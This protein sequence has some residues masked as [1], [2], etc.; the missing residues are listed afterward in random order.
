MNPDVTKPLSVDISGV[1][2][3]SSANSGSLGLS[4]QN[5]ITATID[6]SISHI[7]L[8]LTV[9][10]SFE[11]DFGLQWDPKSELYLINQ[12]M[13]TSFLSKNITIAI[14]IG[15]PTSAVLQPV[16]IQFPFDSLILNASSSLISPP[17]RYFALKRAKNSSQYTLGR[18]FLQQAYITANY[19]KQTFDLSRAVYT[20]DSRIFSISAMPTTTASG[21]VAPKL[22]KRVSSGVIAAIV[23]VVLFVMLLVYIFTAWSLGLWPFHKSTAKVAVLAHGSGDGT[24]AELDGVG[25]VIVEVDSV[26]SKVYEVAETSTNG[27][28]EGPD[29]CPIELG[30]CH[31]R[32]IEGPDRP[33]VEMLGVIPR[34]ELS[35]HAEHG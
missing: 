23:I 25:K 27:E 20:G 34:Y 11:K 24:K 5:S 33:P 19:D 16:T 30:E 3:F 12:T 10:Q 9:C 31:A 21:D 29:R 35:A 18:A 17:S 4:T 32:E 1:S 6:S 8:P 14:D 22:N 26:D 13:Y 2:Y 15:S 28:L 7:W